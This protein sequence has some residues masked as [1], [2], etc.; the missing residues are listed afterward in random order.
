MDN[1]LALVRFDKA[2]AFN[3][4]GAPKGISPVCLPDKNYKEFSR[5]S[6]Y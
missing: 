3:R 6:K 4:D 5:Y 1:D 2:F